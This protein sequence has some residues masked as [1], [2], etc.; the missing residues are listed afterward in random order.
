MKY[1]LVLLL[2]GVTSSA[3]IQK[4]Q[5]N[6]MPWPQ[7][8]VLNDGNF[9]LNKNFKVNITGNPNPRIF[10]GVTRFLRRLDGRTG[11]FFQQGFITKLNEVPTAELQINCTKS[12]KIGLYEDESYHLDIKQ[13]QITINATSDLGALHGLETLLQMLQN[14]NTSF[15]FPISQISDFPRFTWRGLMIDVARHFQ[16]IDV[17]KRNIDGLAAMKMNVFHW[18]L[19]DDQ[20]WR[21]EMKKHK[22]LI[23][24]A[25]DGM[26]YTQEEIKNIVKYADERGILV[27]PEIDVPGHGSAILTA[28]PEIGSKV[29]TL[30][31]G[32]SEKNIQGTA[33]A[34][35]GIERNAGIFSP[36]LDPSNPK[37]YQ[38]LSE[39]F[40]EVCPLF[41][42]AYF[43]IGG[44]ENEGKDWDSNPKI[45][46]FMKKNKLANNHELQTYF[47][48]QLV[49]MLKK[50]GKQ[51]M[52]WEE[53]MTKNMSKDAIIHSWRGPNEGMVAGQSLVDAVK[54]GYKTVLSNGY[55]ID[56]MYPVASHYLNDPMPKGA[57]LTAE[58]KAR[59]LGGEATM[60]TELATSTTIDS[61]LWP[62][63]AAIA[64]RLWSAE[65]ITDL[66]S[67]RKRLDVVSFRLEE[68]GLT[69]IRNKAVILRNISNNQNIKSLN[70]FANV[71]EPLK[72]Y[73]RNKGGTEYQ[74]Y[75]PFTLF[76]DACGPDAKESLAFDDAVN[77]YLA[78]KTPENKEKVAAFFNKWIA[79][80]KGLIELSANAPLVQPILPLSKKLN[81]A[82]QELLLVLDNKSTL[83][84]DDL[85]NLIEQC[86]TKDHADVE[87]SVYASLKK[88]I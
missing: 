2:A 65:D 82:S 35:Y 87:L 86:N 85:K 32:T 66:A 31:G 40:D 53:I 62:R 51:L 84:A 44:D 4:E 55:Y 88:L 28:Y 15:Y 13:N 34:T 75:S 23:D 72:G 1:L 59:I 60:W 73:T 58:E 17:V 45:Q 38:L 69:H 74:M 24:V 70:E 26:Y 80:N 36:T 5:L 76:A 16:P 48:M 9:A 47:T 25:S 33:I 57:N 6:L 41:P 29:I 50:H 71:C 3:Q 37:T 63:T 27:V 81:D 77:Q 14:N 49:P 10:S 42:G 68:L 56:L 8:V 19:V 43:H 78:S 12:G 7:S 79:V 64:E 18:H 22:K 39:I 61:R 46:E 67:M 21:I 30:T 20:G 83:K 11:M 52:G 54:K